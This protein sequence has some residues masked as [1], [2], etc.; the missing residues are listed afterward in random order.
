MAMRP[1]WPPTLSSG[2]SKGK[3]GRVKKT[4]PRNLAERLDRHRHEVLAFACNFK[5]PL[6]NNLAERDIRMLKVQ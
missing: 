1:H 6:D 3:R 2:W 4:K 5:V